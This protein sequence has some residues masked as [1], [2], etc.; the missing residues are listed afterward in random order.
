MSA[1]KNPIGPPSEFTK[2]KLTTALA[3]LDAVFTTLKGQIDCVPRHCRD[4]LEEIVN[5]DLFCAAQAIKNMIDPKPLI[6]ARSVATWTDKNG[7]T[8]F[9]TCNLDGFG[10]YCISASTGDIYGSRMEEMP[11]AVRDARFPSKKAAMAECRRLAEMREREPK[12][13]EI[14]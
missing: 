9:Y 13:Q 1:L 6:S 7:N 11:D 10:K 5:H 14:L 4:R 8:G 3:G 2:I 12:Q